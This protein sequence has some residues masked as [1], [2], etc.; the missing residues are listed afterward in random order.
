MPVPLTLRIMS[1]NTWGGK[2]LEPL[3]HFV[4]DRAAETDL[5]C[6]QEVLD[7]P[8]LLRLDCGFRTT[9][10]SEL[11][12]T[13]PDFEGRFDAVVS[14]EEPPR[15]DSQALHVPFGLATFVRR[16]V[17][18]LERQTVPIIEHDDTLDAVPGLFRTTRR[19][20]MTRIQ[21]G[22]GSLVVANFHGMSR[23][24]TKL[25]SD[26]RLEQ[27]RAIRRVLDA[28]VGPAALVGDFNLLPDTESV[29]IVERGRRNLV[30]E[31]QIPTTRSRLNTYYGTPQEQPHANYAILTPD[32]QVDAFWVPDV[33]VSDHLPMCLQISC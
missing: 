31:W 7:A 30:K 23:P 12:A 5:F 14:W 25:D 18:V 33:A 1:L 16:T 20:Q 8:A 28:H 2:A 29:R 27:S 26:E 6:F 11:A 9:L 24:G 17:P 15:A 3:L 4:H 22:T 21:A 19:L 32:I 10:F 13:L